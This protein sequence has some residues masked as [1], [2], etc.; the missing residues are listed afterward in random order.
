MSLQ[1]DSIRWA[2]K[3]L[4]KYSDGDLFPKILEID[5]IQESEDDFVKLVEGKDLSSFPPGSCRRFIV[6]KDEIAYRQATQLDPQ[7]SII[8]TALIH[9]YG[10]GIEDRRLSDTKIFSY[11]FKPDKKLGLYA[12]QDSWN[13]FWSIASEQSHKFG[14]I[15]YCDIADFYN[16]IYHHTVENQLIESGFSNQ[17]IKWIISLLESTTAKVSR[18]LPIGPHAIHLIAES[19]MIPIDNSLSS[20]GINFIRFADD[21]IVFCTSPESGKQALSSIAATL[22]KQQRLMLQRH[23]TKFYSPK[24]FQELCRSM[25]EDR[26][27]SY[28]EDQLLKIIRK[29]SQGNPYAMI[30]YNEVSDEDWKTISGDIISTIIKEY[31]G[32]KESLTRNVIKFATNWI[33]NDSNISGALSSLFDR[34]VDYIRLRWFYRRLTQIGHPGAIDVSLENLE[35]LTPCFANICTYLVSVQSVEKEKWI[36]IGAKLLT[37]LQSEDVKGNEYFRLSILSLFTRNKYINHFSQLAQQYSSSEPFA[38]REILLAAKQNLAFD[39]LREYKESYQAM[40]AWQ[41]TAYIYGCSGWPLDEK[42]YFLNSL[43]SYRP[44]ET[45]LVKWAKK[46]T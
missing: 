17:A 14:T 34:E 11:R 27:I 32:Q 46:S 37:L 28:E 8:L 29:Y 9:Q 1:G 22:D 5:A 7:D 23:K 43:K 13:N 21:I 26:P 20:M 3:F 24:E 16:Q 25:I 12:S 39:W 2:I 15:L 6:P 40:D 44:F 31:I 33:P 35:S 41:K 30:S 19:A 4:H 18:G 10:Q 45:I 42:K 38:R 36:Q